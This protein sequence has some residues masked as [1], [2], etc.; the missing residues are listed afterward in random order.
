LT[1]FSECF[2]VLLQGIFAL[3]IIYKNRKYRL[4]KFK[5]VFCAKD[6]RGL[7]GNIETFEMDEYYKLFPD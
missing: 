4:Y 7:L 3:I 1:N 6:D 2:F 5:L